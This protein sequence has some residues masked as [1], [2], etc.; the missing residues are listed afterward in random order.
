[1]KS[2][3]RTKGSDFGGELEIANRTAARWVEEKEEREKGRRKE[4]E[5]ESY[6]ADESCHDGWRDSFV[7]HVIQ[8]GVTHW[9]PMEQSYQSRHSSRYDW[10]A[11]CALAWLRLM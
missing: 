9:R 3:S 2:I 1:M 8:H 7:S 4:E 11:P 5:E 6:S 10:V